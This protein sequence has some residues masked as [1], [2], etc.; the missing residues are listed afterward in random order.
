MLSIGARPDLLNLVYVDQP[1]RG[2]HS[3]A[4]APCCLIWLQISGLLED[5]PISRTQS[6]SNGSG[7]FFSHPWRLPRQKRL[8]LEHMGP[9]FW[10]RN[11]W[12]AARPKDLSRPWP[13]IAAVYGGEKYLQARSPVYNKTHTHVGM[14]TGTTLPG[15]SIAGIEAVWYR[16]VHREMKTIFKTF[17]KTADPPRGRQPRDTVLAPLANRLQYRRKQNIH[18]PVF[19][20]FVYTNSFI[21]GGTQTYSLD[22]NIQLY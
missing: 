7:R 21:S 16:R 1:L 18:I 8:T 6:F 17:V 11:G 4:S 22:P 15:A 10:A 2:V 12:D 9:P 13:I 14:Y 5:H 3:H 20:W 19:I